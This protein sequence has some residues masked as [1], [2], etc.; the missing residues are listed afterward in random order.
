[1]NGIISVIVAVVVIILLIAGFAGGLSAMAGT[2][3]VIGGVALIYAISFGLTALVVWG[4]IKCALLIGF[5]TIGSWTIAF[6]WPLVGFVWLAMILLRS[7]FSVSV[8]K[9]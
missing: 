6:S 5:T 1:M 9:D 7:I 4:I 3:V 2:F 8:K